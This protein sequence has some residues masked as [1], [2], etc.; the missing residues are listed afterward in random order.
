MTGSQD[1]LEMTA[2]DLEV[3]FHR[4]LSQGDTRGVEATLRLLAIADPKRARRL[5]DN[6]KTALEIV[7]AARPSG[8]DQTQQ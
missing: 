6:L 4:A 5:Y 1:A 7:Q 8:E 2:D 3:V